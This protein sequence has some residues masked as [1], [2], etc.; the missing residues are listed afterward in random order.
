MKTSIYT[1]QERLAMYRQA[2]KDYRKPGQ[3]YYSHSGLCYY[4]KFVHV[5]IGVFVFF[6]EIFPELCE[7]RPG[8]LFGYWFKPGI[9][10]PRIK[11]L[12][13]AIRIIKKRYKIK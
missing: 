9:K 8:C 13:K 2:V 6:D 1:P 10:T 4:F 5:T 12:Q 3:H 11:C 7:T